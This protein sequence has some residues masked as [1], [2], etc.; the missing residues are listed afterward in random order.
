MSKLYVSKLLASAVTVT[1]LATI[2]PDRNLPI[3]SYGVTYGQVKSVQIEKVLTPVKCLADNLYH[4]A[5]GEGKHGMIAIANVTI[6]RVKHDKFGNDV[7][8]VVYKPNAFS[9]VNQ[10]KPLQSMISIQDEQAYL[11]A[12][13]IAHKALQGD[14]KDI[15][16]GATHYIN[17]REVKNLPKW[18]REYK[19][20]AKIGQHE[21][22]KAVD[23]KDAKP[24]DNKKKA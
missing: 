9:W 10:L 1:A 7:C 17:K 19:K 23:K 3:E 13:K 6:N 24:V 8:S 21:F 22:Y 5:R 18:T 4:E 11:E 15:T 2:Q 14:L 20:T 12:K 16:G